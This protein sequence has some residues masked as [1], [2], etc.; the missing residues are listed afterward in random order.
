MLINLLNGLRLRCMTQR[1]LA[2]KTGISKS[3]ICQA[4]AGRRKLKPSQ[5]HKIAVILRIDEEW[6]F[7][8]MKP[9]WVPAS[10]AATCEH[11]G[12]AA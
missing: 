12:G 8:E 7:Q 10:A 11:A 3:V 5:R 6:A 2:E 1:E 9:G 4:I